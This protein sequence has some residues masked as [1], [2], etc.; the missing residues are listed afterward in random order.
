M[1]ALMMSV[2]AGTEWLTYPEARSRTGTT[3][4]QFIKILKRYP[5]QV[6]QFPGCRPRVLAADVDRMMRDSI[7]VSGQLED[8]G[9]SAA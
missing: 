5:I 3:P 6:R 8:E 4:S 7:R 2:A 9:P 1:S